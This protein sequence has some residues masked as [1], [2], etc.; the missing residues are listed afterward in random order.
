MRRVERIL[1]PHNLG[2]Q[3]K[4]KNHA[5]RAR[6]IWISFADIAPAT[7]D[8]SALSASQILTEMHAV[9]GK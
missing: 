9:F 6:L 5:L 1:E 2:R 3:K 7:S 4:R 8:M